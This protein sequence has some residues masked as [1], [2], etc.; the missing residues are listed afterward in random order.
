M[1]EFNR[2]ISAHVLGRGRERKGEACLFTLHRLELD[3]RTPGCGHTGGHGGLRGATGKKGWLI[4]EHLKPRAEGS[5][6]EILTKFTFWN[7]INRLACM[8]KPQTLQSPKCTWRIRVREVIW[9][10]KNRNRRAVWPLRKGREIWGADGAFASIS[11]RRECVRAGVAPSANELVWFY[12][13]FRLS[14]R[15]YVSSCSDVLP[16]VPVSPPFVIY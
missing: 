14:A 1:R 2:W 7:P 11:W 16:R 10:Q 5:E 12:K 13:G 9:G 8:R 15:P 3:I 6:T 4:F